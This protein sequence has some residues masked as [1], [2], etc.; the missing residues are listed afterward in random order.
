M[1]PVVNRLESELGDQASVIRL[2]VFSS[3]GRAAGSQLGIRGV[4]TFILLDGR[5][6]I[7]DRQVGSLNTEKIKALVHQANERK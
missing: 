7:L 4:P 5:G 2:D 3:V 6:Q 1:K